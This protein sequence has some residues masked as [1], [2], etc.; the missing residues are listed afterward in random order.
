MCESA[1]PARPVGM[2]ISQKA[3]AESI[4]APRRVSGC[5]GRGAGSDARRLRWPSARA[6]SNACWYTFAKYAG[7]ARRRWRSA[8]RRPFRPS[9]LSTLSVTQPCALHRWGGQSGDAPERAPAVDPALARPLAETWA[10][11]LEREH[12]QDGVVRRDAEVVTECLRAVERDQVR[13][14]IRGRLVRRWP[15]VSCTLPH[16]NGG[17]GAPLYFSKSCVIFVVDGPADLVGVE[18]GGGLA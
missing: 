13:A 8:G 17:G 10:P 9:T 14:R 6:N 15:P 11:K 1:P 5:I 18:A 7:S 4:A 12:E 16:D 3:L 2:S